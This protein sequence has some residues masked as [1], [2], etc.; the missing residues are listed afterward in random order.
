MYQ[1]DRNDRVQVL[2]DGHAKGMGTSEWSNAI[3]LFVNVGGLRFDNE[4]FAEGREVS[5]FASKKQIRSGVLR[6]VVRK[7]LSTKD[8]ACVEGRLGQTF[9]A[10]T[11]LGTEAQEE[12]MDGDVAQSQR[13]KE[14]GEREQE[15][16]VLLFV[17]AVGQPYV[18]LGGERL[19]FDLGTCE[20]RT[21]KD[22]WCGLHVPRWRDIVSHS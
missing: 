3:A 21:W 10:E 6:K 13:L 16:K 22:L 15:V 14:G 4:F 1:S 7:F 9:L 11:E 12:R 8:A 2:G 18:F 5:W 20:S 17:R 19:C